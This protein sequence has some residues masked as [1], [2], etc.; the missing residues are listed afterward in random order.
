M[1]KT[2]LRIGQAVSHDRPVI[3]SRCLNVLF[4][5][6]TVST[7]SAIHRGIRRSRDEGWRE[8]RSAS[9]D[10]RDGLNPGRAARDGHRGSARPR[11]PNHQ[12][13]Q[14]VEEMERLVNTRKERMTP[15]QQR[16]LLGGSRAQSALPIKKANSPVSFQ[17]YSDRGRISRDG[18]KRTSRYE[19]TRSP[20][21]PSVPTNNIDRAERSSQRDYS[22]QDPDLTRAYVDRSRGGPS[23][24]LTEDS[25]GPRGSFSPGHDR[26]PTNKMDRA[27]R[28]AQRVYSRQ[29]RD[30]TG[31]Y[32]DRSRGGPSSS[33]TEDSTGPRGSFSPGHD[34]AEG[35]AYPSHG[36]AS[37]QDA[38]HGTS[39]S[40]S[41][42]RADNIRYLYTSRR[43]DSEHGGE[44]VQQPAIDEEPRRASRT[45]LSIPYTTPASEFL[46]GTSVIMAALRSPKRQLYKLYMYDG[47]NREVLA[48][49]ESVRKLALSRDVVVTRLKADGVSLMDKM[50]RG[51][52]HNVG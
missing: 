29:D 7:N 9:Y 42:Y 8:T 28:G 23:S 13:R 1:I 22:R 6:R 26:V 10:E 11:K 40:S 24:S 36:E 52:P 21:G 50:S 48:R 17:R 2:I 39:F 12:Q 41:D 31:A 38:E 43:E 14:D 19:G 32:G 18:S 44:S 30:L 15:R 37:G 51:R 33:L 27:E 25:T 20:Y 35:R 34:H 5:I 3:P 45:P 4:C 49:D 47:E 16:Y 46:Y